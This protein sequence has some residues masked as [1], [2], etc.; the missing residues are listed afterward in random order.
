MRGLL[1]A[2]IRFFLKVVEESRVWS[3]GDHLVAL[4]KKVG[5]LFGNPHGRRRSHALGCNDK[6]SL[7]KGSHVVPFGAYGFVGK[8]LSYTTQKGTT[9][10]VL[11]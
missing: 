10:E 5:S 8:G 4:P 9:L 11:G 1:Q 6:R 3:N 7:P 2:C